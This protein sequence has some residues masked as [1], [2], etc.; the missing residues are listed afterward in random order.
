MVIAIDI[1]TLTK[2]TVKFI[3]QFKNVDY[4]NTL[5]NSGKFLGVSIFKYYPL[6]QTPRITFTQR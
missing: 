6:L 1:I 4:T 2:G 5:F 3:K